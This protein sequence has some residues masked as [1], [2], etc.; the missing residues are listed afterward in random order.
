MVTDDLPERNAGRGD[1]RNAEVVCRCSF[2][3]SDVADVWAEVVH[4]DDA[5]LPDAVVEVFLRLARVVDEAMC[6]RGYE[7]IQSL[8]ESIAAGQ[9]L[10]RTI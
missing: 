4:D 6:E 10:W 8:L 9:Q 2:S 3:L 7:A 1:R 5:E